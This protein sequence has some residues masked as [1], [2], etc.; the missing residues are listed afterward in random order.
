MGVESFLN[1]SVRVAHRDGFTEE[2]RDEYG[3]EETMS[4]RVVPYHRM[5]YTANGKQATSKAKVYF[6]PDVSVS[7]TD[8]ITLPD[9]STPAIIEMGEM[10]DGHGDAYYKWAVL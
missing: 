6:A 7:L 10:P 5:F 3:D 1:Q 8:R 2:G 9:G 4:A